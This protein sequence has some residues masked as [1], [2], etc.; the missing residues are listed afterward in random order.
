ML[1]VAWRWAGVKPACPKCGERSKA[2]DW[3]TRTVLTVCGKIS[4]E[5]PW[6]VCK[7][8]GHNWSPVDEPLRLESKACLSAGMLEWL[9]HLGAS[10]SSFVGAADVLSKLTGLE[11]S[12]ETVRP[13]TEERGA[14][15][16]NLPLM[17]R[18]YH[19]GVLSN[20]VCNRIAE[21]DRRGTTYLRMVKLQNGVTVW[22]M[23]SPG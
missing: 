15:L 21:R 9:I 14:V 4:F 10:C 19:V 11:V 23:A 2:R 8:C 1:A 13:R 20:T 5:R 3:L 7:G 18:H 12:S 17:L 22:I 16:E 6:Y